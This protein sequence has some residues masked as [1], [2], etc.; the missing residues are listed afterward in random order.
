MTD[1]LK[2]ALW[3][4]KKGYSVIP[5]KKDK[6][7]FIKW[8]VYQKTPPT[9]IQIREWWQEWPNANIAIIT[10]IKSGI[11]VVDADSQI[12]K[13]A[14]E[15]FLPETLSLPV[16][17]TPRGWHFY[18]RYAKNVRNGVQVLT[19]CDIR[20]EG[21]YVIAP[22]SKNGRAS[23]YIWENGLSI[24]ENNPP[25]IPSFLLDTII[26]SN[27]NAPECGI[28]IDTNSLLYSDQNV[29]DKNGQAWTKVDT[30]SQGGRDSAL[31]HL[32]NCLVKG[33][34]PND[35]IRFFLD[36][37]ASHCTPPFPQ[38]EIESKIKSA[39]QRADRRD[40]NIAEVVREFVMST[41][42]RFSSA[43]CRQMSGLS[44][45]RE[46]KAMSNV[47]SKMVD[48]GHIERIGD[49]NG[50]FRRVD[51][52]L[53]V[54]DLTEV[55]TKYLDIKLPL[56]LH[57]LSGTRQRNIILVAGTPNVGKTAFMLNVAR[58]N[59]NRG[60]NIRYF[61]SEM[62]REELSSRLKLFEPEVPYSFWI[63]NNAIK[64][65]D[66]ST[67]YADR[68]DPDGIN[69]I[70]YLEIPDKF[71]MIGPELKSF[72]DRLETGIAIV[73]LQKKYGQRLG[74]GAEFGEEKPRLYIT[75]ESNP[76]EGNIATII[77]CKN[78][79]RKDVS[80]T[81]MECVFNVIQGAKIRMACSWSH[82]RLKEV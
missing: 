58:L 62:G 69:I 65:C 36:F 2:A 16:V 81:Y 60:M 35:N 17:K 15:E 12:G 40:I 77:K 10:G 8:Q 25:E 61:T 63:N 72:Y 44:T 26:N 31:F 53:N 50:Q 20:S 38:N 39:L 52:E 11:T 43:E 48:E 24:A 13:N 27:Q 56:D 78:H 29:N 70:D 7:P 75:L 82:P 3:Y 41:F 34:M 68:L 1:M 46:M 76:P 30:L 73:A 64:F 33:R 67:G 5:T 54:M 74:R 47:L 14:I 57:E 42:G 4:H 21:G 6:R 18:F 32:A 45:R 28:K 9:E 23:G 19:D 51:K 79:I 49:K 80:P 37:F 66:H 59:L 71:W 22:P 55:N